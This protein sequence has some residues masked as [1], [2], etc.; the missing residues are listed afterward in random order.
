RTGWG[1]G[2][3]HALPYEPLPLQFREAGV[4]AIKDSLFRRP[5]DQLV[6]P[7]VE[8]GASLEAE[9]GAGTGWIAHTVAD[10][11][12]PVPAHDLGRDVDTQSPGEGQGHTAHLDRPARAYVVGAGLHLFDLEGA[13][14]SAGH[15]RDVDEVATLSPVFEDERR[16]PAPQPSH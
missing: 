15:V 13:H 12:R 7:L 1:S 14:H 9:H 16:S 5:R 8:R 3:L 2:A 6:E 10:I 4:D 11:A